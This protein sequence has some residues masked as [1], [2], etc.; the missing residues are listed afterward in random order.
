MKT[1][2][3]INIL[4]SGLL[5]GFSFSSC[6]SDFEE[7][8]TNQRVLAQVDP[9]TIGNVFA[10]AQ[11]NGLLY[12]GY[13]WQIAEN[14]FADLYV[15]Y[16]SDWQT[17]FQTDRHN[18]NLDWSD[19]AWSIFFSGAAKDLGVVLQKTKA[20][21]MEKQYAITQI[22]K[23]LVYQRNT[24]YWGPIPYSQVNNGL[25]E[26][27]YDSQ[28]SIYRDFFVQ[29]DSATTTLAGFHGENA[30]GTNDQIY[31]GDVDKWI[32]FANTLRLRVAMRI[33]YIDPATAKT[34]AEKAVAA[35]VMET[36]DANAILK[37]TAASPSPLPI[38]L[39]W[40][41]FRMSATME[42]IQKGLQDPRISAYW[43][44]AVNTGLYTGMRNGLSVPEQSAPERA[45]DNISTMAL[46]WSDPTNL[47]KTPW[48]VMQASEAW[49]LRAEGA[50]NGWN[51][52]TTAEEAY[53][54]GIE[55]SLTYWGFTPA[56]VATY[57]AGTTTPV[58]LPD[59]NTPPQ[60]DIV[61]SWSAMDASRHLEQ[62][63][64]QKWLGLFPDG[65]EAWSENRRT[66]FPKLYPVIHSDD[67]EIPPDALMRRIQFQPLEISTNAA[68]VTDA[69]TKLGGPDKPNTRLWWNPPIS[70]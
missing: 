68:A 18:M 64:T 42:S 46:R 29:L 2:K 63:H 65:W 7:I 59:F 9:A 37:V 11:Y 48:E 24:D 40:N 25:Q 13:S 50:L 55:M 53:N 10:Y 19:A 38:M 30:F 32:V 57:Q 20:A 35:G 39:P 41:E 69:I 15:Q 45:Y 47:D 43:K 66:E 12:G 52:G 16:Y 70:K 62:I 3:L 54:K 33:S 60:S 22:Y 58:A 61:V 34:Q 1:N 14:L 31:A 17:K 51:M 4:L 23:V 8:N 49:F 6:T 56:Q 21:G 27:P 36:N 44:P 28:E 67:P 26:V 5:I